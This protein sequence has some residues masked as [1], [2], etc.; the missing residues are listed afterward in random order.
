MSEKLRVNFPRVQKFLSAPKHPHWPW[1]PSR[2]LFI[3]HQGLIP[4]VSKVARDMNLN[5]VLHLELRLRM[6]G[7]IPPFAH[8][9]L[10]NAA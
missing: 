6:F 10:W 3:V 4:K 8:M 1:G 9:P 2:S 7:A 5:T